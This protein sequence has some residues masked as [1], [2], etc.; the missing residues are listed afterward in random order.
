MIIYYSALIFFR[1]LAEHMARE[2]DG[3]DG[4]HTCI[5]MRTQVICLVIHIVINISTFTTV[6]SSP[7]RMRS[8]ALASKD[9]PFLNRHL[10]FYTRLEPSYFI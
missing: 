10:T 8:S 6:G 5:D 9:I 2:N 7:L 1:L 4:S 3:N